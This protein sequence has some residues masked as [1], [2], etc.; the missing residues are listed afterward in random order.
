MFHGN[1]SCKSKTNTFFQMVCCVVFSLGYTFLGSE[2]QSIDAGTCTAP[3][4]NPSILKYSLQ[5]F[6]DSDD[7]T[8]KR[9]IVVDQNIL[10]KTESLFRTNT[11]I[12]LYGCI[13]PEVTY[14]YNLKIAYSFFPKGTY[15]QS[16]ICL[17]LGLVSTLRAVLFVL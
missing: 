10:M 16:G 13:H 1:K 17:G 3:V 8:G 2:S 4:L 12:V 9:F 14:I 11:T 5:E 6:S 15:L 7:I